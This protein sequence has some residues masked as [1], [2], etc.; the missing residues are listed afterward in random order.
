MGTV[1]TTASG[2]PVP[3]CAGPSTVAPGLEDRLGEP[4]GFPFTRG[5]HE[6]MYRERPWTIRQL[7][8]FGSAADTNERYRLLLRQGATGINGVFDYPS[9]RA[10]GSD[11]ERAASDVG[12]GGV[13]V[14]VIDDFED[15]FA[16]IPLADVSVSLVSSQP[17]GAVPHLAMYLRAAQRRGVDLHQLAG[18]S[19]NDFLMETAITIAP[20]ALPPQASF[21]LE[22]DLVEFATLHLPRW[23]PLSVT[24]YNYREAGAEAP[25]EMA[26]VLA[27]GRA[28]AC[29]LIRRGH[30]PEAFL[31]RLSFFLCA[32]NDF[33]E[34][35]AKFRAIR[36]MW[37]HWVR[38]E[39][40]VADERCQR[41][42]FH[43][44]TSGVTNVSRF[45]HV[46]IAR[47][48]LQALAAVMGGTQSL[49]VNGYDEALSIPTEHAAL[50]AL[51][52]Q[53]VLLHES[54]VASATDP[55]GGSWLVEHLTDEIEQAA[56]QVLAQIET[57][58]GI[59][60]STENGWVHRE[61]AR[62]AFDHQRALEDGTRLVVGVNTQLEGP[63]EQPAP[64]P[65]PS[66]TVEGQRARIATVLER[67]DSGR[68]EQALACLAEVCR[69]D[70][71][72][73][74]AALRAV[75]ADVTL[76]EF[77]QVFRSALGTWEFPLW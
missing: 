42:R 10:F 44:Q 23:N 77:G 72:V 5:L 66:G 63:D 40:G 52:T 64:F 29:E 35:I 11:D 19:Q 6:V 65:L 46:N 59:V 68:A 17:I 75:D 57:H 3:V 67:R 21:R 12:R 74:D 9:L 54:G 70:E 62:Q 16:G 37:S 22:C 36:R 34:E 58:G 41:F 39:L 20:L 27:H 26:L 28:V 15:L 1:R 53:Y 8:G 24:G 13:A 7:A 38:D 49:H 61:L 45:A 50:T 18:T 48:A 43:T 69:S 71:N 32:H 31:P 2:I 25:L 30:A 73:M 47:S 56:E 14:D 60:A 55:L 76:G 4:G 33:F 51:R